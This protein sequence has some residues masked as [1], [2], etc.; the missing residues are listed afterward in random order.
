MRIRKVNRSSVSASV[1]Y[2][3]GMI[4][5]DSS[6]DMARALNY[7]YG[8]DRNPDISSYTEDEKQRAVNYWIK[9]TD[10]SPYDVEGSVDLDEKDHINDRHILSF[11]CPV[12]HNKTVY[13]TECD[14]YAPYDVDYDDLC[15]CEECGAELYARPQFDGT[16]EFDV[17]VEESTK[18]TSGS[19]LKRIARYGE[20]DNGKVLHNYDELDNDKAEELAKQASI[21]DPNDTYYVKYDDIMNPSSDY[22]WYRGEKYQSGDIDWHRG[23]YGPKEGARPIQ[24]ASYD[25][26]E[27]IR[28]VI[29]SRAFEVMQ[30]PEFGFS[31][32]E[33]SDYLFVEVHPYEEMIEVEVRAE[34]SYDG[35]TKLADVLN[36]TIAQYYAYAYFDQEEPGIMTAYIPTDAISASQEIKR[37]TIKCYESIND[38]E[39]VDLSMY[40]FIEDGQGYFI[41]R[42]IVEDENGTPHG[43]WAAQDHDRKHPPFKITYMQARGYDPI[44]KYDSD[45]KKLSRE[46]GKALLPNSSCN[47]NA[48][49]YG[50]AY[51][52]DPEMFF[53]KEEIVELGNDV[54]DEFDM[55]ARKQP[56]YSG[57]FLL[58]DV[59]MDPGNLL[60]I[61]VSNDDMI[62]S[63]QVKIDMRKIRAPKDINKY[64]DEILHKLE[65]DYI[66]YISNLEG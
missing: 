50:G 1:K 4:V 31:A 55:W 33:V 7:M 3:N 13:D 62:V 56:H 44:D 37:S 42:R 60:T 34:L 46:L 59:F 32:E 66:G 35:M 36:S 28:D 58:A 48:A 9:K 8:T 23:H 25:I 51:D 17:S 18:I 15:I 10:P 52:I 30:E 2:P 14:V 26:C 6:V 27:E 21:D 61:D 57:T 54:A 53:T 41:Y 47:V 63:T 64:K 39:D 29:W 22:N 43:K 16:I 38:D 11:T 24:S 20:F 49:D 45:I 19:R 12:C 5:K 65:I 40:E